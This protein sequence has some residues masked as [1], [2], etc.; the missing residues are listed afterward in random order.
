MPTAGYFR[1]ITWRSMLMC[2][3][4]GTPGWR[5][6]PGRGAQIGLRAVDRL[7]LAEVELVEAAFAARALLAAQLDPL[8]IGHALAGV[9]HHPHLPALVGEGGIGR[10]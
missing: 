6:W 8:G 9:D 3:L 10:A 7:A 4:S 1:S 5:I 2:A